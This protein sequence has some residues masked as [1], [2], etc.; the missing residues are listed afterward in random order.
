MKKNAQQ[1]LDEFR[2][3]NADET[4][5]EIVESEEAV[6][7]KC[8][9]QLRARAAMVHV[10]TAPL[11]EELS[12]ATERLPDTSHKAI[13]ELFPDRFPNDGKLIRF[14]DAHP[15]IARHRKG[16]R[17]FA[18][19]AQVGKAI[20][21]ESS[22]SVPTDAQIEGYLQGIKKR[23]EEIRTKKISQK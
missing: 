3:M 19:L 20:L 9:A 23:Q 16:Q 22:D 6:L 1:L 17:S 5:G 4:T 11:R 2:A 21:A 8:R 18:N 14:L 7:E 12:K 15:E 10:A 13:R